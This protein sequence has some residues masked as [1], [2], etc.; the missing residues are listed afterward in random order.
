[1]GVL[2]STSG[3]SGNLRWSSLNT[4]LSNLPTG[5]WTVAMLVK[6]SLTATADAAAF[7][8]QCYLLTGAPPGSVQA[9]YSFAGA[10]NQDKVATDLSSF[11]FS[12]SAFTNK[13][14]PYLLV[15]SKAAGTSVPRLGWKL[16]SGGT[17]TDENLSTAVANGTAADLLQIASWQDS[18]F[19]DNW[20]G[21]CAW[22]SGA[23]SD[24][25]KQSL[26][27]NWRTSD[28]WNSAHGTPAFLAE[29]NVAA[30]SVVDYASNASGLTATNMTLDSGE[31]M[32]S[33]NFDG[34]ASGPPPPIMTQYESAMKSM[35]FSRKGY[36]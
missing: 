29:F 9:G 11:G 14:S 21:V 34:T 24:A 31:T 6:R 33:W 5:A 30:G 25:N 22:W 10:P 15:L 4:P 3:S 17:W 35:K 28:L 19:G 1:M 2:K 13:T 20:Y 36:R 8:G 12:P 23:M 27:T 26:G 16:G 32:D 18:D 7:D